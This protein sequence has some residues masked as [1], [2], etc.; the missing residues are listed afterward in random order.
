MEIV[1]DFEGDIADEHRI[2]GLEG[3]QSLE[4]IARSLTLVAN[5]AATGKIRHRYPFS[6]EF[7]LQLLTFEPGSFRT[8]FGLT[9]ST[10]STLKWVASIVGIAAIQGPVGNFTTDLLKYTFNSATGAASSIPSSLSELTDKRSGDF[11]ALQEAVT[12]SLKRSHTIIDHGAHQ[13]SI[14][15]NGNQITIYDQRSKD[16]LDDSRYEDLPEVKIVSTGM[17]NANT[18]NGRVFDY[19]YHKLVSIFVARDCTDRAMS[20]LARSLQLYARAKDKGQIYIKYKVKRNKSGLPERYYVLDA[21]F[22][23]EP[24][25]GGERR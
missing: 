1:I 16:F 9:I 14:I 13:I 20:N 12:P 22:E 19:E 4:G 3:T 7:H 11:E 17:L 24:A 5:F 8:M 15:G 21:W 10:T 6:D 25:P 18:R 23:G 2:P